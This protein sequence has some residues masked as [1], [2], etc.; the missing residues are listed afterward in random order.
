MM[1][2][3]PRS[4]LCKANTLPHCAIAQIQ[5][6]ISLD[7]FSYLEL[8][9]SFKSCSLFLWVQCFVPELFFPVNFSVFCIVAAALQLEIQALFIFFMKPFH[10]TISTLVLLRLECTDFPLR[11][12][13][14]CIFFQMIQISKVVDMFIYPIL[15]YQNVSTQRTETCSRIYRS[16]TICNV[17][18]IMN[19]F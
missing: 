8:L 1:K 2:S 19:I 7:N 15:F 4:A 16:E 11:T 18:D 17:C 5:T 12:H 13:N 10:K 3:E 9:L 14:Y 6:L